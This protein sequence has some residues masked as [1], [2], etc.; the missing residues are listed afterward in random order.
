MT[1]RNIIFTLVPAP[2]VSIGG[3]PTQPLYTGT[4]LQLTCSF[5][6]TSFVDTIVGVNGVWR[7][8]GEQITNSSRV[9]I[10]TVTAI[11]PSTFQTTAS[12]SPLSNTMDSGQYSCQS[13]FMSNQFVRFADAS[14]QV[15]VMIEG[16]YH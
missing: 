15:A 4:S 6:L 2:I 5:E 11:Q 14:N 13:V 1:K 8:G 7:R 16:R 9:N 10:S 12:I 3:L